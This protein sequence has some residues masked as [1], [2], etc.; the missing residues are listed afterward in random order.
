[1]YFT[2]NLPIGELVGAN[3]ES[4]VAFEVAKDCPRGASKCKLVLSSRKRFVS[5]AAI[6]TAAIHAAARRLTDHPPN[7]RVSS[8][9]MS[10][11]CSE[12]I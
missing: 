3:I 6:R 11:R 5:H 9:L 1:M 8:H 2:V 10:S 7:F 4:Q 12:M